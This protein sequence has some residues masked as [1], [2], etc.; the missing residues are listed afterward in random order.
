MKDQTMA[1]QRMQDYIEANLSREITMSDLARAALFSPWYA[2]RLFRQYAGLTPTEYIRAASAEQIRSEAPAGRLPR[3][4]R[5][6]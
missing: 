4:R 6:L 1:V 2:Y 5:R 3:D